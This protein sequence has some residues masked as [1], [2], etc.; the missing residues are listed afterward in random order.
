LISPPPD[1]QYAAIAAVTPDPRDPRR[2][3]VRFRPA[4][5]DSHPQLH[6]AETVGEVV[7]GALVTPSRAGPVP[8]YQATVTLAAPLGQRVVLDAATGLPVR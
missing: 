1:R 3:T 7:V 5:G 2:L 4:P 6:V 8:D